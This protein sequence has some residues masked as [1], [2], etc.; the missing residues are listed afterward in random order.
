[1]K[2]IIST[3]LAGAVM[4]SLSAC[5]GSSKATDAGTSATTTRET[6]TKA[7]TT[8]TTEETTTESSEE[9]V[10]DESEDDE[11]FDSMIP[12]DGE[13][14]IDLSGKP[15][16]EI[17]E[18]VYNVLRL[19]TN[20]TIESYVNRFS[21]RPEYTYEDGVWY[22]EWGDEKPETNTFGTLEI[23]AGNED[24]KIVLDQDSSIYLTLSFDDMKLAQRVYN[25][26]SRDIGMDVE[27]DEYLDAGLAIN[28]KNCYNRLTHQDFYD[29][30][31]YTGSAITIECKI[32]L[33]T[34]SEN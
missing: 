2:K 4:L 17:S 29:G 6:T 15:S 31:T 11:S 12:S 8:T 13:I 32:K 28:P 22:F 34:E 9:D 14:Y 24:G 19:R 3:V 23:R 21:V 33:R 10:I 30:Y 16:Y 18:N 25:I 5:S 27:S 7:T 20:T 1:M 26:V